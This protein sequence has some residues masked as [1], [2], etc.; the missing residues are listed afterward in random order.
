MVRALV[1]FCKDEHPQMSWSKRKGRR[2]VLLCNWTPVLDVRCPDAD[3]ILGQARFAAYDRGIQKVGIDMAAT[4]RK[5]RENADPD[6][7]H[8]PSYL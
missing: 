1:K 4:I 6:V 3:S 7:G 8:D 5:F 2:C